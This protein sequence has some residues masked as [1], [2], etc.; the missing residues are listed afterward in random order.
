MPRFPLPDKFSDGDFSVFKKAFVRVAVA[1]AWSDEQR[2]SVLPL[3]L[4]GRAL[5][6]FEKNEASAKTISA[7][8]TA[9]E[10]E[11]NATTDKDA[12]LK[13]FY[14]CVWGHGLDLDVY[15]RKLSTLL[16]RGL[17]SLD[18]SDHDRIVTNQFIKGFPPD[19]R[20]RF[21]LVFAGRT[22]SLTEALAAA[23]DLIKQDSSTVASCTASDDRGELM[24][25][26]SEFSQKL[27]AV[28][29]EVASISSEVQAFKLTSGASKQTDRKMEQQDPRRGQRRI[30][31]FNCSGFGHIARNCPSPQSRPM[32]TSGNGVA[33]R[34]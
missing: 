9:L 24:E 34:R 1:N 5:A 32:P 2:L 16:R 28:S 14:S 3:C 12:A 26:I 6:S 8:L 10:S 21:W 19:L 4:G 33:V 18:D 29:S 30:R 7:A 17:S 11:F 20:N 31:C 25:K 27:E 13:E 15:A 23:K 22:P